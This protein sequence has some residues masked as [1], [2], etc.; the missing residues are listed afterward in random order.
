MIRQR[1]IVVAINKKSDLLSA[2]LASGYLNV[3]NIA[4]KPFNGETEAA[5]KLGRADMV[6][7]IVSSGKTATAPENEGGYG[8]QIYAPL[9]FIDLVLIGSKNYLSQLQGSR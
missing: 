6:L 8:L 5:L 9:F 4:F 2:S 1:D 3:Q 7:E